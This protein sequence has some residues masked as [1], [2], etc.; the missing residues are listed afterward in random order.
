MHVSS[1]SASATLFSWSLSPIVKSENSVYS[2]F[3]KHVSKGSGA[4]YF[5]DG[6]WKREDIC[7]MAQA[8]HPLVMAAGSLSNEEQDLIGYHEIPAGARCYICG[9]NED[10][11]RVPSH[12]FVNEEMVKDAGA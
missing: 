10:D 12:L 8:M 6:S 3:L 4:T 2:P 11:E 5:L 9:L 7:K 1:P